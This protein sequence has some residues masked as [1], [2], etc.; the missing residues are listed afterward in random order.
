MP[1]LWENKLKWY[2]EQKEKV[3]KMIAPEDKSLS[4]ETV[5]RL[6][7]LESLKKHLKETGDK[8]F[9]QLPNVPAIMEAYRSGKLVWTSGLVTYWSK[10]NPL[11]DKPVEYSLEDFY[12][13]M[14]KTKDH[15]W[16]EGVSGSPDF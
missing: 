14:A 4:V 13:Y 7:T 9:N 6:K 16:V 15:V 1:H 3:D 8:R 5:I 10:G 12:K 2:T 11:V